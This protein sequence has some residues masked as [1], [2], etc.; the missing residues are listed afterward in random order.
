MRQK[1]GQV[2][3]ASIQ[4]KESQR[5][6]DY[7]KYPLTQ[8]PVI[9]TGKRIALSNALLS[10][11]WNFTLQGLA[12]INKEG[13]DTI[14]TVIHELEQAGYITHNR[15]RDEKGLLREMEYTVYSSP[16]PNGKCSNNPIVENP[17]P[18]NPTLEFPFS[19]ILNELSLLHEG[20]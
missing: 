8:P 4:S 18:D 16:K 1:K 15:I 12:Y 5:L 19:L 7:A 11:E 9:A 10:P 13:L 14:T 3:Y 2:Y 20:N 6:Y 17:I